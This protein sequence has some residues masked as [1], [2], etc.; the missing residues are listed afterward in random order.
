[1]GDKNITWQAAISEITAQDFT[2]PGLRLIRV[3]FCDD[4]P[5]DNG[6]GVEYEDFAEIKNSAIGTPIKMRFMGTT[7][8]GHQ[9]SI[10]IGYIKDMFERKDGDINQL[11]ADAVLFAAEYPDEIDYLET[12]FA[13]GEAPGLSWE[14]IYKNS[15]VKNSVEWLKGILTRAAT[16]VRSPAYGNRTAIL[17]LASS[18]EIS[19]EEFYDELSALV[20]GNSPKNPDKGGN[21]RMEEE[22]NKLKAELDAL[23]LQVAEKTTK[24]EELD[25]E[26]GAVRTEN[27][28]LKVSLAEQETTITEFSK[29]ELLASRLETI[30][31]AGIVLENDTEKLNKKTDFYLSFSDEAFA[32]YVEDLKVAVASVKPK[33]AVAGRKTPAIPRFFDGE[34]VSETPQFN[35]LAEKFKHISRNQEITE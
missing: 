21:N 3:I 26:L 18:T 24:L 20:K 6:Q 27:A 35:S 17:A 1:M 32:E 16:F 9:G 30:K 12:S 4:Q 15:V 23:K 11:I 7:A 29:K 31:E 33:V 25:S 28:A 14:L 8:G 2:N 34:A 22:L 5:N 19:A 10:P 13:A